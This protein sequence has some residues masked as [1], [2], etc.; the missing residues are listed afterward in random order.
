MRCYDYVRHVRESVTS[1]MTDLQ[2]NHSLNMVS[3]L[4]RGGELGAVNEVE[5]SDTID[6]VKIQYRS[7]K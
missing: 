7:V 5:S 1:V 4:V 3:F 2:Y 6:N